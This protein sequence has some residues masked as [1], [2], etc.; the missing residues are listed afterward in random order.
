MKLR[1]MTNAVKL[2]E[3]AE[4]TKDPQVSNR[5]GNTE[6]SENHHLIE[7]EVINVALEDGPGQP[8]AITT[9]DTTSTN[10]E[11]E[12]KNVSSQKRSA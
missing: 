8:P 11:E 2:A 10:P 1:E 7:E 12:T 5:T 6:Y 3:A 9:Q 4:E